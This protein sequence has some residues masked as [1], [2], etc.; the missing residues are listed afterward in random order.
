[1][2]NQLLLY[3]TK[4]LPFVKWAGGK[5]KLLPSILQAAPRS[6]DRYVEPFVGGGAVALT[7][8]ARP[9]CPEN[10]NRTF[11]FI[12]KRRSGFS[13]DGNGFVRSNGDRVLN[14]LD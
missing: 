14:A 2:T 13:Y 1:M 7:L 10:T 11:H 9:W 8:N 12:V 3:A 4:S 5:R 6:Y